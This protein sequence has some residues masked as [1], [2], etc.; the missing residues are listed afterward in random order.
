MTPPSRWPALGRV[1][2]EFITSWIFLNA[3]R[4]EKTPVCRGPYSQLDA[5]LL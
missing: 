2:P 4:H 5:S 1:E 3:R